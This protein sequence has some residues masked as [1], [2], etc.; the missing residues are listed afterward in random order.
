MIFKTSNHQQKKSYAQ[1]S[2]ENIEE[3]LK[4]KETFFYLSNRE[5]INVINTVNSKENKTKPRVNMTTKGP[6]K[7]QVIIPMSSNYINLIIDQ[8]NSHIIS[9]NSLL[10]EAKSII[11]VDFI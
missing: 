10:K 5:I 8:A 2:K 3:V 6:S 9:I 1:V 7:K 11:S 4:I